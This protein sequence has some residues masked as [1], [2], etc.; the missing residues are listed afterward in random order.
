MSWLRLPRVLWLSPL[1]VGRYILGFELLTQC[2]AP[3]S[4]NTAVSL[5][6][7]VIVV[8]SPRKQSFLSVFGGGGEVP[9]VARAVVLDDPLQKKRNLPLG[10]PRRQRSRNSSSKRQMLTCVARYPRSES[11]LLA[12]SVKLCGKGQRCS[13]SYSSFEISA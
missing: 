6:V 3:S 5:E 12:T 7:P 10:S 9:I 4:A 11:L 13:P 1:W 8:E 2:K